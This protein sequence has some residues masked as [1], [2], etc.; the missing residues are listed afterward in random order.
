MSEVKRRL[1]LLARGM[2]YGFSPTLLDQIYAGDERGR[3]LHDEYAAMDEIP[4]PPGEG[5]TRAAE[6]GKRR[7]A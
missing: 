6:A 5:P 2:R 3:K 7:A 1:D 4:F